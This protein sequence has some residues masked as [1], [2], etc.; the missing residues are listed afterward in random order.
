MFFR[1]DCQ[2]GCAGYAGADQEKS[3][4]GD[5]KHFP[6]VHINT[7]L[8]ISYHR[9][10]YNYWYLFPCTRLC[11][12]STT[13]FL[14]K[15]IQSTQWT[16]NRH[17]PWCAKSTLHLEMVSASVKMTRNVC[18]LFSR[19]AFRTTVLPAPASPGPAKHAAI[20][21]NYLWFWSLLARFAWSSSR[22]ELFT[23]AGREDCLQLRQW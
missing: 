22:L 11:H 5:P 20:T 15:L 13:R 3:R 18:L 4:W 21:A 10:Q 7:F 19:W 9:F 1:S 12:T 6:L 17:V 14:F 16:K 8:A 2:P 23:S